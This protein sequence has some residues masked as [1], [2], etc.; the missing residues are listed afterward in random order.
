MKTNIILQGDALS[1]LKELPEKSIN[2]CLTSPPYW[3]L[4]NY[5][6]KGQLGLEA[7]FQEYIIKLC[8]TFD[9]VKKV[10]KKTGTCWVVI[11]DTY[12]GSGISRHKG[13]S[14]PK[15]PKK[16][17]IDYDEPS[18]MKQTIPS[19]CLA[20]I[21]SRFA[22]EM[23]NRGWILRSEIIWRKP[24]AMPQSCKNR[25]TI[26]FEKVF[27]F[28]KNKKYYFEQQFEESLTKENRPDGIVRQRTMNYK[29]KFSNFGKNAESFGSPR[30]RTQRKNV[31]YSIQP[32]TKEIVEYRNLPDIKEFS[33]YINEK[34]KKL[35]ITIDEVEEQFE[36]QAPH[37]WFNAE[38]FPSSLDYMKLKTLLEL[39]DRYT[40]SMKDVFT[41]SSKKTTYEQGKN[42][43][44]VWDINTKPSNLPHM[45]IYPEELCETPIKAGCPEGGI[46]LDP[47]FGA[48]TTGL[49]ALKQNK[50]FIG[51]ELNKEY[52]EIANKRLKPFLE[53]TKL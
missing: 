46:V 7:T 2:M 15:N 1:K 23:C 47:F 43:R 21:P 40:K 30:A 24:N 35:K 32:R 3:S 10:L 52:I 37:H 13:Y 18:A 49:V 50:R 53:Q 22:I 39:D 11:G 6:V 26:D 14:D 33:K 9:E 41:K 5:N 51:I 16:G 38:S 19:K 20:Q 12:I 25:F 36:N 8:D 29:G 45:A 44:T 27:M 34:R 4:R 17:K 31:P 42:M 28:S 48:G